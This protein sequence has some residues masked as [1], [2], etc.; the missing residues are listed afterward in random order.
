MSTEDIDEALLAAKGCGDDVRSSLK[1]RLSSRNV[2]ELR[3][4][5]KRLS[6]KLT[7]ANRKADMVERILCMA[8]LGCARQQEKE[9]SDIEL[10]SLSYVSLELKEKLRSLPNFSSVDIWSKSTQGVLVDFT[11]M[12]LLVYLVYGRDKTFDM[13]SMRAFKSLKAYKFFADGFVSNV[14][15]HDCKTEN[16]R[17]VFVRGFVQHSLSMDVP[18]EVFVSLDGDAG[19]VFSAQCTCVSG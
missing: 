7:G 6:I 4:L 13:E 12:N 3:T 9:E 18:L 17:I 19:D 1:E 15:L 2:P 8:Q 11:F 10:P 14:W 16:P 5:A